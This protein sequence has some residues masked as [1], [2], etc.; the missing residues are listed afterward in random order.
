MNDNDSTSKVKRKNSTP[1]VKKKTES[2]AP[3]SYT[4]V[5]PK[6][7][8]AI[9]KGRKEGFEESKKETSRQIQRDKESLTAIFGVFASIIAFLMIEVQFLKTLYSWEKIVGFSIIMCALLLCFNIALGLLI[10][11]RSDAQVSNEHYCFYGVTLFLCGLGVLLG[12]LIASRGNEEG[13]RNTQIYQEAYKTF[14][15]AQGKLYRSQDQKIKKIKLKTNS[16]L[17]DIEDRLS[18]CMQFF[19]YTLPIKSSTVSGIAEGVDGQDI[20]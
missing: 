18:K 10:Q 20:G 2:F 12:G 7:Q 9:D 8:A 14:E 11:V 19:L 5:E 3:P 16:K 13:C 17:Q 4:T 15:E 1:K 6:V